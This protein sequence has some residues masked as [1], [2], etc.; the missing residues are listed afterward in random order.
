M[1]RLRKTTLRIETD[2]PAGILDVGK[3]SCAQGAAATLALLGLGGHVEKCAAATW[4][5]K[6][7]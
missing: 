3:F 1:L 5:E 6:M 7:K 4:L 2:S